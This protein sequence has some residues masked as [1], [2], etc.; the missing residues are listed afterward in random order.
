MSA[1]LNA[2]LGLPAD[3]PA[4]AAVEHL[5]T[6][7]R[8]LE[9]V[10]DGGTSPLTGWLR[11]ARLHTARC[12]GYLGSVVPAMATTRQPTDRSLLLRALT[13]LMQVEKGGRP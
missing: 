12:V 13:L 11:E 2:A 1:P 3:Y 7:L 6:A 5:E 10:P 8:H 4:S 9:A